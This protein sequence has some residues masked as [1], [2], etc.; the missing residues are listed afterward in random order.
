MIF[1]EKKNT[2]EVKKILQEKNWEGAGH[3]C[4]NIELLEEV[5]DGLYKIR[6]ILKNKGKM[7]FYVV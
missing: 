5:K 1:V 4:Y 2:D 7:K 3:Y 6:N